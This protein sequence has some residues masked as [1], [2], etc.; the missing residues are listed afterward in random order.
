[1][2]GDRGPGDAAGGS[3][4]AAVRSVGSARPPL[5]LAIVRGRSMLPTLAEGDRLL[6]HYR[7]PARSGRPLRPGRLVVCLPPA[8][9]VAVKRLGASHGGDWRVDSDNPAEGSD[10]RTFGP[11]P[12]A[13]II[14]AVVCRVW[15]RPSLLRRSPSASAT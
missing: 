3:G 1:M 10:S 13:A 8:R 12:D 6:V 14:A 4:D 2:S 11:L 7:G 15:P 9:P 5:G